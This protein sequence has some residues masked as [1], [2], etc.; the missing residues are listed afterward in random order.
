MNKSSIFS[1]ALVAI[2][3]MLAGC[4]MY[5]GIH[6]TASKD[7]AVVVKGLSIREVQAD[8][9]VWPLQFSI[10]GND[11]QSLYAE[12]GRTEKMI[13]QFFVDKGFAAEDLSIGN[14]QVSDNWADYYQ[15]RPENH[16]TIQATIVI[17]THEVE[18]VIAA[19]GSQSELLNKGVIL[20]SYEWNTNYEYT[21][22]NSLKPEM[23]EEATKNARQVAQKF[24]DDA[25]CNLGS[26]KQAN[27]GQFSI[28]TDSN[29][30][31]IKH[32]RV[33]TTVSY[34]LR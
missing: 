17:S 16:Y 4:F 21:A 25:V 24:A 22:L 9:V 10:S 20:N 8:Y 29:R 31:W 12:V 3:I 15:H 1:A 14:T 2:G 11:L 26:I 18:K 6:E 23:I 30:P 34:F 5:L 13:I 7:R 32:I 27:Q 19:Q 33:V 28:E